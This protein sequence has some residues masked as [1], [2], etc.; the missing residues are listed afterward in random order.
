MDELSGY[1]GSKV[2]HV[3]EPPAPQAQYGASGPE[4][5]D[6]DGEFAKIVRVAL[7]STRL[8]HDVSIFSITCQSKQKEVV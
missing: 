4:L 2:N 6:N 3:T 1:I 7:S 5:D 8:V